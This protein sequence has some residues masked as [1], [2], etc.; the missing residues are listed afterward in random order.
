MEQCKKLKAIAVRWFLVMVELVLTFR[1]TPLLVTPIIIYTLIQ[2]LQESYILSVSYNEVFIGLCI[3]GS[4]AKEN[5]FTSF[6]L[7][8]IILLVSLLFAYYTLPLLS[9][10]PV[11][12]F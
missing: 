2:I 10:I 5:L 1:S 4:M 8:N 3:A 9:C 12:F 11:C 7:S 6:F